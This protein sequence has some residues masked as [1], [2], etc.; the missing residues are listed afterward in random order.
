ML[1]LG[2]ATTA[3]VLQ[4]FLPSS[5]L[6]RLIPHR[7]TIKPPLERLEFVVRA[8]LMDSFSAFEISHA[9][10]QYLCTNFSRHDLTVTSFIMSLKVCHSKVT[11]FTGSVR[12][13]RGCWGSVR[14]H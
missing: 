8:A 6:S 5:A 11:G 1:V 2:I 13:S 4:K 14:V 10:A 7:F 9:V 12:K 3:D